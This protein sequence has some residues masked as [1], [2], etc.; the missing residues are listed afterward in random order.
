M[1][2]SVCGK[3]VSD[4]ALLCEAGC[5]SPA[6]DGYGQ[7]TWSQNSHD[8]IDCSVWHTDCHG[9]FCLND[10]DP[11]EN[12][13]KFCCYCGK[14]LAVSHYFEEDDETGEMIRP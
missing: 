5:D 13:M 1:N 4:G 3:K 9:E 14:P 6:S 12:G 10:G 11:K 7:C 8:D 2:C